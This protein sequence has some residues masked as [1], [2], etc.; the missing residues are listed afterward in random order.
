MTRG[1]R[2]CYVIGTHN[3]IMTSA[4][5]VEYGCS[6]S[7]FRTVF[8]GIN[9]ENMSM[10]HIKLKSPLDIAS[11]KNPLLEIHFGSNMAIGKSR[12]QN[13]ILS[14]KQFKCSRR[15]LRQEVVLRRVK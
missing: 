4:L 8:V 6:L 14:T 13:C 10:V 9:S 15:L 1:S 5:I 7:T 2:T 3:G 12:T 11:V